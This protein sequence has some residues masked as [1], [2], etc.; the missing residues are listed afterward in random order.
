MNVDLKLYTGSCRPFDGDLHL[1]LVADGAV[2]ARATAHDGVAR[3]EGVPPELVSADASQPR[4]H[5]RLDREAH[6]PPA[7]PV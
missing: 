3:F 6:R 4:L 1:E 5:V 2:V 7:P